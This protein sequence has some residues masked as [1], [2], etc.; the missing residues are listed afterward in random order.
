MQPIR[1]AHAECVICDCTIERLFRLWKEVGR[2]D[3]WRSTKPYRILTELYAKLCAMLIQQWLLHQGCWHDP[4]RSLF[5]AARLLQR[6]SNRVIMALCEGNL[7]PVLTALIGHLRRFG[8]R[9]THRKG[10]PGTDQRLEEGLD[11]PLT[12]LA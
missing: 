11:W 1:P 12:V 3:E 8:G 9:L 2:V 10:R 7:V 4:H 6:E 5:L